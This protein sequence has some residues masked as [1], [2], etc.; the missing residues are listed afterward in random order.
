MNQIKKLFYVV[1]ALLLSPGFVLAQVTVTA[2]CNRLVAIKNVVGGLIAAL[3]VVSILYAAFLFLTAGGNEERTTKAKTFFLYG[4]IGVAV[5]L[6][7]FVAVDSVSRLVPG[8]G[9]T[10]LGDCTFN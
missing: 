8:L 2:L 5:A 6:F 4:V 7:A 10:I 9:Q 3:A 1:P